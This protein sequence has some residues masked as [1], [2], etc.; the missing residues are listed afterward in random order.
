MTSTQCQEIIDRLPD[1][2]LICFI[3]TCSN[4]GVAL[5]AET[6]LRRRY[7]S[8][9]KTRAG[10]RKQDAPKRAGEEAR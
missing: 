6:Q 3:E 8:R 9:I 10:K 4:H 7:P 5:A 1:E 2:E